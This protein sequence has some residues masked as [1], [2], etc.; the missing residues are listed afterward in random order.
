M[1]L[2]ERPRLYRPR[3]GG[4]L[5]TEM[6]AALSS[7]ERAMDWIEDAMQENERLKR[8]LRLSEAS[9]G[10][11]G[12][13]MQ[14]VGHHPDGSDR[15]HSMGSGCWCMPSQYEALRQDGDNSGLRA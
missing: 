1:G 8:A 4:I 9:R 14:S 3:P 15:L 10:V 5:E 7:I 6:S 12:G 13:A 11:P 2:S